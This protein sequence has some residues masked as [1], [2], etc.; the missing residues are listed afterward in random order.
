MAIRINK[1]PI[2]KLP[3]NP[4]EER[5]KYNINPIATKETIICAMIFILINIL[6]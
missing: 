3:Q 2:P 6:I 5:K 4:N 1:T